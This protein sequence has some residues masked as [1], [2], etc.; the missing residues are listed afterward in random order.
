MPHPDWPH[1]DWLRLGALPA[2]ELVEARLEL[3]WALQ[4]PAALGI[5]RATPSADFA[6]HA[7]HWEP[8]H[9]A[10]VSAWAAQ[11][12]RYR[13]GL[14]FEPLTLLLLTEHDEPLATLPLVGRTLAEG[15]A[16]L[17][18]ASADHAGAARTPLAL[19]A[20]E[21]PEHPLASGARFGKR[22]A[23]ALELARWFAN[24]TV[25]LARRR[26]GREA[27]PLR[28]WSHHFDLDTVLTLGSGRTLGLGF[29]PG[30]ESYA[31]PYLYALPTPYPDEHALPPLAPPFEWVTDGWIGAVLRG[32]H[33]ASLPA[34]AQAAL[35]ERFQ[36]SAEEALG[37]AGEHA[38]H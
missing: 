12:R 20:H 8:R 15:L 31:E 24:L 27:S 29:S 21:L 34:P 5:A 33:V 18:T 35:V 22:S 7:L 9:Q 37:V 14:R 28:V 13:A 2:T 32:S 17:E 10:L 30:D 25:A 26:A 3:H 36:R 11:P 1:P 16:W 4:L 23:Q 19:P 38:S 6:Q